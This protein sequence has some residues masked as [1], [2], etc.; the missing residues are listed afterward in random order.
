MAKA[1]PFARWVAAVLALGVLVGLAWLFL[2]DPRPSA[3]HPPPAL[4]KTP[5]A[6]TVAAG[7]GAPGRG[8]TIRGDVVGPS[9]PVAG[10]TVV[11]TAEE[12]QGTLA[13]AS[14]AC[15]QHPT[16]LLH[17]C[18]CET[19]TRQLGAA[20]T[21]RHGE[22]AIAARAVT[23]GDGSFVLDGLSP[24][25]WTIWAEPSPA[26][27]GATVGVSAGAEGVR[28]LL[29]PGGTLTGKVASRG[30]RPIEGALVTAIFVRSSRFFEAAT[31]REGRYRIGPLPEGGF[32]L[33]ASKQGLLPAASH[34]APFDEEQPTLVLSPPR[35]LGGRVLLEGAPVE[36]AAVKLFTDE[37]VETTTD[38]EGRFAFEGVRAEAY[39]L[40]ARAPGRGA[41]ARGTLLED[42]DQTDLVL[43]LSPAGAIVGAVRDETGAPIAGAAVEIADAPGSPE[44]QTSSTLTD[45]TGAYKIE[46][47]A[48]GKFKLRASAAAHQY[49]DLHGV[50]RAEWEVKA[51]ETTTVDFVLKRAAVITGTV[52]NPGGQPVSNTR[53]RVFPVGVATTARNKLSGDISGLDG[54]FIFEHLEAGSYVLRTFHERYRDVVLSVE[55]P[56]NDVRIVLAEGAGVSGT[57]F[58]AAGAALAGARVHIFPRI[59]AVRLLGRRESGDE[60]FYASATADEHG[61]YLLQGLEDGQYELLASR[62]RSF[63]SGTSEMPATGVVEIAGQRS[64]TLDLRLPTGLSISGRVVDQRKHG[65][66]DAEVTG[67]YEPSALSFAT[68]S[69]GEL[70]TIDRL[71]AHGRTRADGTFALENLKTG[72]WK[73]EARIPGGIRTPAIRVKAGTTGLELALPEHTRILGRVRAA[74]DRKLSG[75]AVNG[76]SCDDDGGFVLSANGV[77]ELTV[78]AVASGFAP[79][80]RTVQIA[81]GTDQRI[82]DL[83]L[84]RGRAV[85]V[86][87]LDKVTERPV[88][89]AA[90]FRLV[91]SNGVLEDFP[92][93][94]ASGRVTLSNL[95][96]ADAPVVVSHPHY[97]RAQTS[98]P[99]GVEAVAVR[100][101][102]GTRIAGRAT[103]NG[104]PLAGQFVT[105][106]ALSS[107]GLSE[108]DRGQV[109]SRA[110]GRFEFP[111]LPG[112]LYRV[113]VSFT[114]ASGSTATLS[115][116]VELT[117]AANAEVSLGVTTGNAALQ[118]KV[119][120]QAGAPLWSR[121]HL[122]RANAA[123]TETLTR[124][125]QGDAEGKLRFEQLAP[126]DYTLRVDAPGQQSGKVDV[127]IAGSG[128]QTVNVRLG[129]APLP[130]P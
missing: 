4:S 115:R 107:A 3:A 47:A 120:D 108:G 6:G 41:S 126:G 58:D 130:V 72:V 111:P 86:T 49:G 104:A 83:V 78:E 116:E 94:A 82:E 129:P 89:G 118:V 66:A 39:W 112:G 68:L 77:D 29:G 61:R 93:T 53:I 98:V 52:V 43:E 40:S 105:A 80:R 23:A 97:A 90:V 117:A 30:Q 100:L 35:R 65:F 60:L 11:A 101:E 69:A 55:A 127:S 48:P 75:C 73:L 14:S 13:A 12:A 37:A 63:V 28:V 15:P 123:S 45:A 85:V 38:R 46:P 92:T 67:S 99:P 10:V 91:D 121:G 32:D 9:G 64:A 79:V 2:V 84:E 109:E 103:K 50:E 128:V 25:R 34:A 51:G 59:L 71:R 19:M 119:V 17:D 1:K 27:V 36:G 70:M 110:D 57:V 76:D 113:Q 20:L 56:A 88:K 96:G 122:D 16:R 31:D 87:V 81:R 8:A 22:A 124:F 74:D 125:S 42:A 54:H 95:E 24:G 102:R 62:D 114:D 106:S 18:C 44:F 7:N 5:L 33:V 26:G 21:A